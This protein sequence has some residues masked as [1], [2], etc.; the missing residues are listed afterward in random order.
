M[1]FWPAGRSLGKSRFIKPETTL[2]KL[3]TLNREGLKAGVIYH[4]GQFDDSRLLISL[5]RSIVDHG[6][7]CFK[8]LQGDGPG[9]KTVQVK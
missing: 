4:D 8:L 1:I 2:E 3:P 9:E 6:R 5:V 7:K